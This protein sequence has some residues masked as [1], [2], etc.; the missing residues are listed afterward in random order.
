M[1]WHA[2]ELF[3]RY[4]LFDTPSNSLFSIDRPVYLVLRNKNS[5]TEEGKAALAELSP[6]LIS[7]AEEEIKAL[8]AEGYL[9]D[10]D[11]FLQNPQFTLEPQLKALCLHLAHD[12]QLRCIY[13]FAGGGAFGGDR[14][15]MSQE[16]GEAAVR[17]LVENSGEKDHLEIDFFGGEPLLNKEVMFSLVEYGEQV[18]AAQG[19]RLH[20]TLTTN[21][22]ELD[23]RVL[24][25]LRA[26]RMGL[27]LSL[28]GRPEVND[29]TRGRGTHDRILPRIL[30][31]ITEYP[32]LNYYVRGTYTR[33]NLDF[34][35]DVKHL[36]RLGIRNIS[37]EPVTCDPKLPYAIRPDDLQEIFAEYDRLARFWWQTYEQ[38]DPFKFFHFNVDLEKS[39]C[40]PKRLLG[41][42]AGFD[43]LAVTPQG[44]LYPCHQFVGEGRFLLGDVFSG[45]NKPEIREEFGQARLYRKEG[46]SQCWARYYCSGNCHANAYFANGNILKP[47]L[48]A[49]ELLK[50]RLEC[51][52]ALKAMQMEAEGTAAHSREK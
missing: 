21:T 45:I 18:A 47:D 1:H 7:E 9:Q 46:C 5:S 37:V 20:F 24:A 51:G 42:G 52:L 40:L 22:L 28:D 35:E 29:R 2:F 15:I 30:E 25:F 32:D 3:D 49:C 4:F 50:K 34:S 44:Q 11:E 17:F 39:P 10:N 14:S 41:C 38:G 43:Y 16:V 26:H 31:V 6:E 19:K 33:Y 23:R 27:I 8:Q 12:C 13:C 36:Y 48:M